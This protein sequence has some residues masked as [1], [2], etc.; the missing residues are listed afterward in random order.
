MCRWCPA[1]EYTVDEALEDMVAAAKKKGRTCLTWSATLQTVARMR[2][3]PQSM[4]HLLYGML[5]CTVFVCLD[6][7]K[8]ED[9]AAFADLFTEVFN[10]VDSK[11]LRPFVRT[12]YMRTAFQIPFDA[13][14][15]VSLDTNLCMI[16]ENPE[17]GPTCAASG[18]WCVCVY[19]PICVKRDVSAIVLFIWY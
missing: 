5:P 8:E 6:Q 19:S 9:K 2:K 12:Q 4:S 10:A 13:T 7:V 15:R 11:Q 14:V 16:R 3:G 1:G 17:D 18:R